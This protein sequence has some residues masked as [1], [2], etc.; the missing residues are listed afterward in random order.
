MMKK[1]LLV[2]MLLLAVGIGNAYAVPVTL[3]VDELY[4]W[5]RLYS[6]QANGAGIADDTYTTTNLNPAPFGPD[7]AVGTVVPANTFGTANGTE[8][9]WGVGSVAS[10]KTIPSNDPIFLR[11][12]AEELTF[13]FYGFD[14][15]YLA[16]PN[17]LGDTQILSKLGHI[18]VYLDN[19]PDFDGTLGTAGRTG[20]ASYTGATE[21]VLVLDL[22]PTDLT[23]LGH[24]L[25]SNFDFVTST[26][27]GAMYLNTTGLGAWDNLYNTNT[28]LFGSDFSF[29]FTVRPNTSPTVGDWV[30]RGDAGG[31]GNVIPEPASLTLLGLGLAGL[32]RLRRKN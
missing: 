6:F 20:L 13:V 19:T 3:N 32:A 14:D 24:T 15:D 23:G 30:V 25:S 5:G 22:A 11:S 28:Q 4:D 16:S 7:T 1:V 29:S 12:G 31:E 18:S 17:I 27:A 8:D 9:T 2:A 21:G 10:I 26:G